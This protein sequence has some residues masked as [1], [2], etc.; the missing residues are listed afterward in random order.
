MRPARPDPTPCRPFLLFLE[1]PITAAGLA[2][3]RGTRRCDQRWDGIVHQTGGAVDQKTGLEVPGHHPGRREIGDDG[4]RAAQGN[5]RLAAVDGL[6]ADQ[7][8]RSPDAADQRAEKDLPRL[9]CPPP[10]EVRGA[11]FVECQGRAKIVVNEGSSGGNRQRIVPLPTL[12]VPCRK[13]KLLDVAE[14]LGPYDPRGTGDRRNLND[15][16]Q[17]TQVITDG[18]EED[19][20]RG[21]GAYLGPD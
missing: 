10:D 17:V 6:I 11:G 13:H 21:P 15:R 8:R 1:K 16:R 20:L 4:G 9:F 12:D 2:S 5:R 18:V 19:V 3:A 7:K 14:V